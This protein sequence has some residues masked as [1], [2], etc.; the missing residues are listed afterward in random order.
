M[1]LKRYISVTGGTGHLGRV[2]IQNLLEQGKY[3]KALIRSKDKPFEHPGLSWIEGDLNNAGALEALADQSEAVIHCASAIS[4]L[5]MRKILI[6]S[7]ETTNAFFI[8]PPL[9]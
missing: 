9:I 5:P 3:V 1:T 8:Y 6:K 4:A 7:N 2:L